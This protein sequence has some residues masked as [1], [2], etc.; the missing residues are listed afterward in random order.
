MSGYLSF[1]TQPLLYHQ[2]LEKTKTLGT[3]LAFYHLTFHHFFHDRSWHY[4]QI[5]IAQKAHV[6]AC[7]RWSCEFVRLDQMTLAAQIA[8]TFHFELKPESSLS[9]DVNFGFQPSGLADN[10]FKPIKK[11]HPQ[12]LLF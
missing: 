1:K 9:L 3:F 12:A 5:R 7:H 2:T 4:S 6:T 11:Q 8:L 10:V